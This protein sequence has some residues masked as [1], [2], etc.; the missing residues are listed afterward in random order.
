M[1]DLLGGFGI[2]FGNDGWLIISSTDL[3]SLVARYDRSEEMKLILRYLLL[4]LNQDFTLECN[5]M[6]MVVVWRAWDWFW[7]WWVLDLDAK[8]CGLCGLVA[9]ITCWGMGIRLAALGLFDYGKLSSPLDSNIWM[10]H[11]CLHD[12]NDTKVSHLTANV[13]IC[14][15][16]F[17]NIFPS[18]LFHKKVNC[19]RK[20]TATKTSKKLAIQTLYV[21]KTEAYR[22]MLLLTLPT[23]YVFNFYSQWQFFLLIYI[24]IYIYIYLMPNSE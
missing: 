8:G 12:L 2:G 24:Y 17:S 7:I 10:V 18:W 6:S 22:T 11:Y 15:H 21:K 13:W 1:W 4:N 3:I 14:H 9:V 23:P 16:L 20:V 5:V 19:K